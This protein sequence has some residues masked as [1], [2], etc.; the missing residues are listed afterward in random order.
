ML[1]KNRI[2]QLSLAKRLYSV[3]SEI[4][5]KTIHDLMA[6]Y[7]AQKPIS[8]V[9][10][11]DFITSTWANRANADI[12]LVGDSLSMCSLGYASTTD[13]PLDEFQYH[14]KSICR[15]EGTSFIVADMPY[16]SFES[17]IE[18]GISTAVSLMKCSSRV[19]AV[20]LEVGSQKNDYALE[21][22]SE[23]CRRGIPVMGHIGL[24]PQRVHAMGGYKVQGSKSISDV[25]AIY[26]RAKELQDV[27]CFSLVLECVP[28][29]IAK[30]I[31]SK[32]HI[33]TIGIGAGPNTSGQ[34]LVMSDLLGMTS[35]KVPKFVNKYS[36]IGELAVSGIANYIEEVNTASFPK[37]GQHTFTVNSEVL[38]EFIKELSSY[39]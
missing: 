21:L 18:K 23:L 12:I 31:T 4:R 28:H 26:L 15:A 7:H 13:L 6:K 20:K 24:T 8:M 1:F 35:G 29:Q 2:L 11:Y 38:Q 14:V 17:S 19:N 32:L 10:A 3:H 16:G 33:P 5:Q 36:N 27:G 37:I 22:A 30:N 9:T 34:V 39:G 25:M